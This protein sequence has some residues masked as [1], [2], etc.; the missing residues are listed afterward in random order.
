[1]LITIKNNNLQQLIPWEH[2]SSHLKIIKI[3][4][5]YGSEIQIYGRTVLL[6]FFL[7]SETVGII[8]LSLTDVLMKY[9]NTVPVKQQSFI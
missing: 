8:K 1:M 7:L 9:L 3:L 6:S 2:S 4:N 5:I